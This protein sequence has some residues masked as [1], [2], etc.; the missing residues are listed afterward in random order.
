MKTVS[1]DMLD[2]V[3]RRL[4]DEFQPEQVWF[5]GSHAWGRPDDGS[6]L[7]LLVIVPESTERS[8]RRA[9]RAHRCLSGLSVATDILV[10]TRAEFE[11][12]RGVRASLE[13]HIVRDGRLL[14]G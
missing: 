14:Y 8:V 9:Q 7:D 3:V 10:K 11:R 1:Q 4:T 5:F 12:F 13:A 6:D 2:D